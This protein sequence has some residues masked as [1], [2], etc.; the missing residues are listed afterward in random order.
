MSALRLLL[1]S[2]LLLLGGC[3]WPVREKTDQV[4]HNLAARPFD[5]AP[6]GAPESVPQ[7]QETAAPSPKTAP[8]SQSPAPDIQTT[9]FLQAA[10]DK[11]AGG[12]PKYEL[13]IPAAL[14]G[15][16]APLI[17]FKGLTPEQKR[18]AIQKL[19]PP[20]PPLPAA[21]APLPGPNGRPYTLADLQQ[22]AA[23][24]S[25]TLRQAVADVETA[26]GN[27]V[28]AQTYN[29]PTVTYSAAPTNNNSN[30]GAQGVGVDQVIRTFGKQ[31][32]QVAA[33]QK[34]LDNAELAL[35]RARSD[36]ATGVRHAYFGLIVAA[37]TVRVTEALARF[38]DE[39]YRLY[40]GYL[41]GGFVASYEPAALRAQAYT[42]RLAYQQAIST[43]VYAWKQ[44]V[45]T[46]GLPQLPLTAVA[47]RVDRLIPCYDYDKVLAHVL[48]RHT[49]VLMA[50]NGLEKAR[51][52]LKLAQITPY[53]DM[54]VGFYVWK[55]STIIPYTL[56]YQAT[57]GFPLPIW[58]QNKGNIWAAQASLVHATEEAHRVEVT[59]TNNLAA[60][61]V[62]Y[63]NNLDALEYYRRFILPDQVRA[64]RGVFQRRQI[65]I[66]A[67]PGDL[68]VAQQTLANGL[69]TYLGILGSLWSAVVNVADF[70]QT[71]DLF[72]LAAPHEL[73]DLPDLASLPHWPCPHGHTA[74]GLPCAPPPQ[75]H[76]DPH[77]VP[78]AAE[79][80]T[81][82][83]T[84]RGTGKASLPAVLPELP[85]PRKHDG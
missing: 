46:L 5:L 77:P 3:L 38:T 49:D 43:Y 72:Q 12:L 53:P 62:N 17:D 35:R 15:S 16:D 8:D 59:L 40:T 42:T 6:E 69:T 30:A 18:Q 28:Q 37:E 58:D 32:M 10:P 79:P 39:I 21:P 60:A 22:L 80:G 4:V 73:P 20:L 24:N 31:K 14:P 83:G 68:V 82:S 33:A 64:Y 84:G 1:L 11:A 48:A 41:S 81:G 65:D 61:Y 51:Y 7:T 56:F 50:Q 71:D 19:Y 44:L 52:N 78:A 13:Q 29:N 55:E 23:A 76:P 85:A 25:P 9:A 54:D 70:L 45:A 67:S 36:L 63:K 47:G 34:D 57:V 2:G 75:P 27:L 66:N 26:R 74:G